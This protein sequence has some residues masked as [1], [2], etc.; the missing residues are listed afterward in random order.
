M[1]VNSSPAQPEN[2]PAVRPEHTPAAGTHRRPDASADAGATDPFAP[3]PLNANN[4]A[5]ITGS[6]V[7]GAGLLLCAM[8]L[9]F[10]GS[11]SSGAPAAPRVGVVSEQQ[12]MMREAMTMAREARAMQR[13]HMEMMRQ[14]LQAEH[15]GID[16]SYAESGSDNN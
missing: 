5:I 2:T 9:M 12:Q 13:E 1:S 7:V 6:C 4:R 3:P 8:G 10:G 15:E 14:N 16:P 11:R